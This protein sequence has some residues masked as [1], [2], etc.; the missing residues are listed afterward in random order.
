M[1]ILKVVDGNSFPRTWKVV[2]VTPCPCA[3]RPHADEERFVAQFGREGDAERFLA[4]AD[5]W[6]KASEFLK[7]VGYAYSQD[8]AESYN[9]A[10]TELKAAV[11][12]GGAR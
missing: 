12:N 3:G 6:A 2:E 8:G 4:S 10:Y 5:L 11:E 1:A 7:H 9:D